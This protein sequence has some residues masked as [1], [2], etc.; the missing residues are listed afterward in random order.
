MREKRN[1]S[2][3]LVWKEKRPF[4]RSKYKWENDT[5]MGLIKQNGRA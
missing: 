3:I 1:K 2:R 5:K 4:G